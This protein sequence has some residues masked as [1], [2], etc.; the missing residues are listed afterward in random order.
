MWVQ[1][2]ARHCFKSF[3]LTDSSRPW[4]AGVR[5]GPLLLRRRL[6]HR[7]TAAHGQWLPWKLRDPGPRHVTLPLRVSGLFPEPTLCPLA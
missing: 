6:R 5:S 4:E 3:T 7:E 2:C 1:V